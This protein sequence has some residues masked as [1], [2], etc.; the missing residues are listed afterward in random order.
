MNHST[1]IKIDKR[2]IKSEQNIE[3]TF[4]ELLKEIEYNQVSLVM[5][6]DKAG[7]DRG[8]IYKNY[9]N[10]EGLL[11]ASLQR[12]VT[13][14]LQKLELYEVFDFPTNMSLEQFSHILS[15]FPP[16][17]QGYSSLNFNSNLFLKV[18]QLFC[19]QAEELLVQHYF[20]RFYLADKSKTIVAHHMAYSLFKAL[21]DLEQQDPAEHAKSKNL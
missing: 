13:D 4:V 21:T 9:K 15:S 17:Y 10:K 20:S 5:V 2:I 6:A 11:N 19:E 7:V 1:S 3:L 14:L 12:I 18:Q 16:D 8:T